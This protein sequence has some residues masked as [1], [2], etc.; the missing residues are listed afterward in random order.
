MDTPDVMGNDLNAYIAV[1]TDHEC[2]IA[3]SMLARI[4]R[5]MYVHL[6]EGSQTRNKSSSK[7]A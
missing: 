7:R 5:G 4:R 2:T 6:R 3:Q 1:E